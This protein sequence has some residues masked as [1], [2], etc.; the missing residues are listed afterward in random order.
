MM[1]GDS[2]IS[3]VVHTAS[4]LRLLT[5]AI[6]RRECVSASIPSRGSMTCTH[7][8]VMYCNNGQQP[9]VVIFISDHNNLESTGAPCGEGRTRFANTV[10][11]REAEAWLKKLLDVRPANIFCLLNL[12]NAEDVDRPETG[13]V[14]SCHVLI[15][16]FYGVRTSELTELLVHVVRS[17]ARIVTNPYSKILHFQGLLFVDDVDSNYLSVGLFDL[18]QLSQEIPEPRFGDDIIGRE[19]T[20]AVNLGIWLVLRREVAADDLIFS[21]AHGQSLRGLDEWTLWTTMRP[22]SLQVYLGLLC[23]PAAV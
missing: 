11:K 15:K 14:A 3:V 8:W 5:I 20:H 4:S 21:E 19:D 23:L 12:D 10:R 18:L 22:R 1:H 13:T 7:I 6:L 16:R 9:S 2:P 17:G